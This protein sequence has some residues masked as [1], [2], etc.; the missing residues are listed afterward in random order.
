M[1][2]EEAVVRGGVGVGG[3]HEVSPLSPP[4]SSEHYL[5]IYIREA[6]HLISLT[7]R[8]RKHEVNWCTLAQIMNS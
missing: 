1:R 3:A 5:S 2:E 4:W 8:S 7:G 6:W